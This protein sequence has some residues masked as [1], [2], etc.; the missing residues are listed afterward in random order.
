MS[1]IEM[2]LTRMVRDANYARA[3]FDDTENVL[4]EYCMTA[5][6]IERFK[7]LCLKDFEALIP[8]EYVPL[9]KIHSI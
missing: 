7:E 8:E 5:E 1:T 6:Q 2:I 3:V 4:A 9:E